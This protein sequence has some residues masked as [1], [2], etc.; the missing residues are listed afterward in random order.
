MLGVGSL[1]VAGAVVNVGTRIGRSAIV[2]TGCSIDHDGQLGER[3]Q[4]GPGARPVG[5]VRCGDDVVVGAGAV[6]IPGVMIGVGAVVLRD[7]A[8]GATMVGNPARP[9]IR[10]HE[11]G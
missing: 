3:C 1:V 8:E 7:V 2:N 10:R 9:I 4:I 6:V 5:A 11:C